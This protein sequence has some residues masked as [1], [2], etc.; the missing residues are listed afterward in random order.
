MDKEEIQDAMNRLLTKGLV[1][2][3]ERTYPFRGKE[4]YYELTKEIAEKVGYTKKVGFLRKN[5]QMLAPIE[6]L[7]DISMILSKAREAI[8]KGDIKQ[9]MESS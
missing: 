8:E 1:V 9:T 2:S 3:K 4:E 6:R 7:H 5:Q